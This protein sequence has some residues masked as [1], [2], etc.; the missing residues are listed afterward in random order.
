MNKKIFTK[1]VWSFFKY[2]DVYFIIVLN[3]QTNKCALL[4]QEK[5]MVLLLT[6]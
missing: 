3:N 1:I 6:K 4:M 5:L 2:I